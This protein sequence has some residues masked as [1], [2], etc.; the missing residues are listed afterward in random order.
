MKL[1]ACAQ[2]SAIE[3]FYVWEGAIRQEPEWR[4]LFKTTAGRYA[5]VEAAIRERHPYE[6]PAIY[7]VAVTGIGGSYADWVAEA[8]S[9]QRPAPEHAA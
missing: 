8:S 1:V 5:D 4:I 2:I 6:L 3:S 9:G 7:G